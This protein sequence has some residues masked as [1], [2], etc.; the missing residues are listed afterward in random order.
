MSYQPPSEKWHR[1]ESIE[2]SHVKRFICSALTIRYIID[3]MVGRS[4]AD[5]SNP[6]HHI[7][8]GAKRQGKYSTEVEMCSQSN[9]V[10]VLK[11]QTAYMHC[12]LALPRCTIWTLLFTGLKF[13]IL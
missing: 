3:S 13:H 12:S 7:Y 4:I 9:L 5:I 6:K 2:L 8:Q 11:I 1:F 10:Y